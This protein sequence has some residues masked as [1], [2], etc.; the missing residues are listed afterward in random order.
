MDRIFYE[1]EVAAKFFMCSAVML[2]VSAL[3]LTLIYY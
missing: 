1:L 2:V 3:V